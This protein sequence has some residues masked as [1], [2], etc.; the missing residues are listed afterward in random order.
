MERVIL[1]SITNSNNMMNAQMCM[2]GVQLTPW[3]INERPYQ[4]G[5]EKG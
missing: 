5:V 1:I 4:D 2:E 3:M